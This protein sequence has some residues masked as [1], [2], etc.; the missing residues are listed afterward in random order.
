MKTSIRLTQVEQVVK[1]AFA[2]ADARAA[3]ATE[4]IPPIGHTPASKIAAAL[5]T[6]AIQDAAIKSTDRIRDGLKAVITDAER[7]LNAVA[8]DA[9]RAV[10]VADYITGKSDKLPDGTPDHIRAAAITLR[11]QSSVAPVARQLTLAAENAQ[12]EVD[13]MRTRW[14]SRTKAA[15]TQASHNSAAKIYRAAGLERKA[16]ASELLAERA[17]KQRHAIIEQNSRRRLADG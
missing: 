17:K 2:L 10:G 1:S 13:R 3:I 7:E 15:A 5:R 11:G 14:L 8:D 12:A 4:H 9:A 6:E 16:L